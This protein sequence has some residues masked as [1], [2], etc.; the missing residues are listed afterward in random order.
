M[1]ITA[2]SLLFVTHDRGLAIPFLTGREGY[3]IVRGSFN[4]EQQETNPPSGVLVYSW[5]KSPATGPV[6]TRVPRWNRSCARECRKRHGSAQDR[7]GDTLCAGQL[8]AA[9]PA[10]F[11]SFRH[12]SPGDYTVPINSQRPEL[13]TN[14]QGHPTLALKLT[15]RSSSVKSMYPCQSCLPG[16][17]YWSLGFGSSKHEY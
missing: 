8:G 15:G 3:P 11:D 1:S 10:A 9:S 14:G 7:C 5:L 17:G 12:A 13:F 6:E 16:T 2:Q 4:E